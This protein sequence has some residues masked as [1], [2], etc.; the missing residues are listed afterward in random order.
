VQVADTELIARARCGERAALGEL[1]LRYAEDI[2]RYVYCRTYDQALAED[3][4]ADVFLR[5]TESIGAYSQRGVPFTA[6]LYRIARARLIDHWRRVGRRPTVSLED[7]GPDATVDPNDPLEEMLS[8]GRLAQLLRR[9]TDDQQEVVVLRFVEGLTNAE[10]A[11]I[12]GKTEGAVKALQHR[13]VRRLA[14]EL[15]RA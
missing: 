7:A 5:V 12:L 6:W 15:G 3:L 11:Q 2:H 1:Y 9:L 10:V 8:N 14:K 4:T 13:A